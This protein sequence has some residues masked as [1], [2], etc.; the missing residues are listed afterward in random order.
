TAVTG[1]GFQRY[2]TRAQLSAAAFNLGLNLWLIPR[3]G[4]LGAAWASLATD[5]ALAVVNWSILRSLHESP[6]EVSAT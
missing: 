2:R 5:G 3:Y 1:M 6:L 4:W